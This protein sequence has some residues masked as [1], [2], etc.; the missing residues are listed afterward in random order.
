MFQQQVAQPQ[1]VYQQQDAQPQQQV[2]QPQQV[3]QLAAAA[4]EIARRQADPSACLAL[5]ER[6]LPYLPPQINVPRGDDPLLAGHYGEW[7][8][9]INFP[10]CF[11]FFGEEGRGAC[12]CLYEALTARQTTWVRRTFAPIYVLSVRRNRLTWV[13]GMAIK[14]VANLL[15]A[16][17]KPPQP[18]PQQQVVQQPEQ[19]VAQQVVEQPEQEEEQERRRERRR[20]RRR[21]RRERRERRREERREE[22]KE[23]RRRGKP[24]RKNF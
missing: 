15:S 1:Q 6:L 2:I 19:Q 22:R 21:T 24:R 7:S 5:G 12:I 3:A 23:K 16:F 10:N 11:S 17:Y 13:E 4:A 14:E 20:A 9:G 18:Q 8:M